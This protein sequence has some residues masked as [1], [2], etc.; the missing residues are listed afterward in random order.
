[1]PCRNY[2][3][4]SESEAKDYDLQ[5][6]CMIKLSNM[7]EWALKKNN[8]ILDADVFELKSE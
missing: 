5:F 4:Y 3:I 1:M 7:N 6:Q 2:H 8:N